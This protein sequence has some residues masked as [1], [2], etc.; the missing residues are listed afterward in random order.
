MVKLRRAVVAAILEAL[1]QNPN[2]LSFLGR[3]FAFFTL[4]R[5]P[6]RRFKPE[7]FKELRQKAWSID[8]DEYR[9][10]FQI[11]DENGKQNLHSLSELG[12]SGSVCVI[13]PSIG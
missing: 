3:I 8:E 9:K 7:L 1:L 5:V 2:I 10:S 11:E 4:I 6:L 12:Y 13:H